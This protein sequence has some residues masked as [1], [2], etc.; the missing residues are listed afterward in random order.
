M[1]LET[2]Y[3]NPYN[4]R[5]IR[6]PKIVLAEEAREISSNAEPEMEEGKE[7]RIIDRVN[8]LILEAANRGEDSI[9]VLLPKYIWYRI[10]NMYNYEGYNTSIVY[11][12]DNTIIKISWKDKGDI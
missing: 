4:Y 11:Q 10:A 9:A 2:K 8:T 7:I 12:D 5:D 3:F 1:A 6:A